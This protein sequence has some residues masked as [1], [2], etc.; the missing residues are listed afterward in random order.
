MLKPKNRNLFKI[1]PFVRLTDHLIMSRAGTP[2]GP[3]FIGVGDSDG[4]GDGVMVTKDVE[5]LAHTYCKRGVPVEFHIYKGEDHTQAAVSFTIA[6][7]ACLAA[8]LSGKPVPSGCSS[9]GRGAATR[10]EIAEVA[11]R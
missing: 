1:A 5:A 9:V 6:A 10:A 7:P 8:R 3:L 2:T 11:R 4:T